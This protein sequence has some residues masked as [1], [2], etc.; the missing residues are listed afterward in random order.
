MID[1]DHNKHDKWRDVPYTAVGSRAA[2]DEVCMWMVKFCD[3][4][5]SQNAIMRSGHAYGI[6]WAAEM[7]V[8]NHME[9]TG[10]R[11]LMEIYIPNDTF[12]K[13]DQSLYKDQIHTITETQYNDACELLI[14]SKV[15]S[16]LNN[17]KRYVKLLFA[18]NTLQILGT[19]NTPSK[20]VIYWAE[21]TKSGNVKGGTRVAVDLAGYLGIPCFNINDPAELLRISKLTGFRIERS[22]V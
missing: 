14:E 8:I 16:Y 7:G 17:L 13:A 5:A 3:Y 21:T 4:M 11:G 10:K 18:R 6:D 9:L 15:V 19:N 2:P 12:N 1:I 22:L 20:F